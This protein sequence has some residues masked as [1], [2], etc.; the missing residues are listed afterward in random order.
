M[1]KCPL[2]GG[3]FPFSDIGIHNILEGNDAEEFLKNMHQDY[4]PEQI[5][6]FKEAREVYRRSVE[7]GQFKT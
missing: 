2:C 1:P 3:S 7:S 4:T 6:F 5:A